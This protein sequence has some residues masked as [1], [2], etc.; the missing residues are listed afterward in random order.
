MG[1]MGQTAAL[2]AML[3]GLSRWLYIYMMHIR[4]YTRRNVLAAESE[5]MLPVNVLRSIAM[6]ANPSMVGEENYRL[7]KAELRED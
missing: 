2:I 3:C 5:G 1:R 7:L 6:G 4:D